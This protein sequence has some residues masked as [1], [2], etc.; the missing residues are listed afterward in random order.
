M[1][2][3]L[4]VFPSSTGTIR[5]FHSLFN[6]ATGS[7]LNFQLTDFSITV[8]FGS[9]SLFARF[10]HTRN[11]TYYTRHYTSAHVCSDIDL[12]FVTMPRVLHVCA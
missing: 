9:S 8:P 12:G 1:H 11:H 10:L 5:H 7:L 2:D 3:A 6:T 4:C